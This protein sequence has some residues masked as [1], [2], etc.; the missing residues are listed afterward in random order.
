M[1]TVLKKVYYCDSCKKRYLSV[2]RMNKHERGCTLNPERICGLCKNKTKDL[3][4]SKLSGRKL[5]FKDGQILKT[6]FIN[7]ELTEDE[8]KTIYEALGKCPY[9][10][11]AYLRLNGLRAYDLFDWKKD[12][13][14]WF[15]DNRPPEEYEEDKN[16]Y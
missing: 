15:A 16:I 8:F 6:P 5:F 4:E 9:C 13:Q 14:D 2:G 7:K 11:L 3:I 10:T 1:K 12:V